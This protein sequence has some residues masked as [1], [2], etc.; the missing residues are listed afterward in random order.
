VT[1]TT[2]YV[3]IEGVYAV[4][5]DSAITGID[6][7]DRP[8]VRIGVKRGSAYD[9]FLTRTLEH[10]SLVRD[11]DGTTEFLAQGLE[12]LAGIRQPVSELVAARPELRLVDG[13]FMEIRQAVGTT[14][15]RRPET[16]DFLRDLVEELKASGFVAESLRRA[17]QSDTLVAPL[18]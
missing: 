15:S 12:V 10:A 5:K 3:V 17:R 11:D 16:A 14:R 1:F 13:R 9:L 8:G 4:P 7:V 2:P 6:E 18:A